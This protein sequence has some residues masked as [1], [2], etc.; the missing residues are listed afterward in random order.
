MKHMRTLG[1]VAALLASMSMLTVT[2]VEAATF[3]VTSNA[4]SGAGTLRWAIEQANAT[5]GLD[6]VV[7]PASAPMTIAVL[8]PLP[9]VTE[10]A[11]ITV[12]S[13]LTID[14]TAAGP[15][16]NGLVLQGNDIRVTDVAL[17]HFS[18]DGLAVS[19]NNNTAYVRS[20][21]NR[22][23]VRVDGDGNTINGWSQNIY[24]K[25]IFSNRAHGIW[26]TA[27]ADATTIG[28]PPAGTC[29]TCYCGGNLPSVTG[30]AGD[31]L[32]ID[33]HHASVYVRV[34]SHNDGDG[35]RINGDNNKLADQG[36]LPWVHDNAGNGLSLIGNGNT[37]R[38]YTLKGNSGDG[39]YVA[40]LRN[41]LV[42][43]EASVNN[44]NGFTL[45]ADVL[46]QSN[47]GACNGNQLI[48]TNSGLQPPIITSATKTPY[49]TTVSGTLASLPNTRFRIDFVERTASCPVASVDP[50]QD[51]AALPAGTITVVT[52]GTGASSFT[53]LLGPEL[54]QWPIDSIVAI[55]TKILDDGQPAA[56]TSP[57][58]APVTVT[59]SPEILADL[60]INATAPRSAYLGQTITI[61]YAITNRGP[62]A[63]PGAVLTL[64]LS[65][66]STIVGGPGVSCQASSCSMDPFLPGEIRTVRHTFT[67]RGSPGD[68]LHDHTQI[69]RAPSD[70]VTS[71]DAL[72]VD[73]A[74]L[75]PATVPTL[76]PVL[77][78]GLA[79]IAGGIA[80][81]RLRA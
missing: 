69:L 25:D 76:S 31:G 20:S 72:D 14:G 22:N 4:D 59:A 9:P 43:T 10:Q 35:I 39:I 37:V 75:A 40:G 64:F 60:A 42:E 5:P 51:L 52:D 18:G 61:E 29:C 79:M 27:S 57:A 65:V 47:F 70:T 66:P 63:S 23:G 71:N 53:A 1:R 44:G 24:D 30:N 38:Q 62:A 50:L 28:E 46:F 36:F 56:G 55:A 7:F 11:S 58:S 54:P 73:I 26:I 2:A 17:T 6:D 21:Y 81:M 19:G 68:V 67:V 13:A 15:D 33:G 41:A 16:A 32:R 49:V 80:V 74:V 3:T 77:L 12:W 8:S 34:I 45:N 48:A 78:A